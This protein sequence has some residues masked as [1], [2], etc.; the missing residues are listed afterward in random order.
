MEAKEKINTIKSGSHKFDD[1]KRAKPK[2]INFLLF[3]FSVKLNVI[4]PH[5]P[6]FFDTIF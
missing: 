6:I 3:R 1:P 5:G 4:G 2:K